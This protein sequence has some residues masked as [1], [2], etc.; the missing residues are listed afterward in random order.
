[1]TNPMLNPT[2]QY[3]TKSRANDLGSS[4]IIL[5]PRLM[6][7]YNC[8]YTKHTINMY[9]RSMW[10]EDVGKSGYALVVDG[11]LVLSTT[12]KR[13]AEYYLDKFSDDDYTGNYTIEPLL[14]ATLLEKQERQQQ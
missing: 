12:N 5:C 3:I 9:M 8:I 6:Y 4:S 14:P 13:I 7:V 11:R 2:E 10:I 1:M